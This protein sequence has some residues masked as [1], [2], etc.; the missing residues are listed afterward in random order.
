MKIQK[1]RHYGVWSIRQV[2]VN[3]HIPKVLVVDDN[4]CAA[5]AL[6]AYMSLERL[7]CRVAYGG[8]AAV[9]I[10]GEWTPHIVL[11]DISMPEI[12]GFEAARFLRCRPATQDI[13]IIA[14][15]ALDEATVRKQAPNTEFDGY[16]QKGQPPSLLLALMQTMIAP[17][18]HPI[19]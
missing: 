9:D 8:R 19:A 15:T 6:F 10:A 13:A 18:S 1:V 5:D 17:A 3:G 12:N 14:F 11:M 4:Q 7:D 16:F 2:P